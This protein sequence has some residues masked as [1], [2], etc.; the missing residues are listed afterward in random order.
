MRRG[1]GDRYNGPVS[2]R[3]G[4]LFVVGAVL[5]FG[6]LVRICQVVFGAPLESQIWSDMARYISTAELIDGNVW[7]PRHFFQPIGFPLL[8]WLIKESIFEWGFALSLLNGLLSFGTLVL[9]WRLAEEWFGFK[10]GLLALIAGSVHLPW[11]YLINYALPETAFTFLLSAC[12]WT[13]GRIVKSGS[14]NAWLFVLWGMLFILA[15]WLK[16]THVFLLPLF[17]AGLVVLE[18]R[19]SIGPILAMSIPVAA[20]LALHG[21]LTYATIGKVRLTA[22]SGG[23]NFVEGK[24]PEKKNIDSRGDYTLSP[25]Y[26]QLDLVAEK[27]WKRPFTDAGYFWRQGLQCVAKDPFVLIQSF[28]S[29][30]YLFVGNT[31]WPLTFRPDSA[32]IRLYELSFS[33]FLLSGLTIRFRD[34][35]RAR[36]GEELLVWGVPALAMFLCAYVFK[37]EAR[38]RVPFDVWLIPLAATGWISLFDLSELERKLG[39]AQRR[40]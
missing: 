35:L 22:T 33:I 32:K 3:Q 5:A 19:R 6:L 34:G 2:I 24:C 31:V 18:G 40:P 10:A 12:A 38:Y 15:L 14:F 23:L 37:G 13:A 25:L 26:F 9:M 29:I 11:I 39:F 27:H 16:G 30:P 36:S 7:D 21:A 17:A 28:E 20:G 8:V 1:S 4:Q